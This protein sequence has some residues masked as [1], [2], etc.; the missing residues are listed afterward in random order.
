MFSVRSRPSQTVTVVAAVTRIARNGRTR[1][2]GS[3]AFYLVNSSLRHIRP[4]GCRIRA[5]AKTAAEPTC[6]Q[7][8]DGRGSESTAQKNSKLSRLSVRRE[9]RQ[10]VGGESP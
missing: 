3:D 1:P 10:G 2:R 9:D 5:V 6:P 4:L 8:K 7:L